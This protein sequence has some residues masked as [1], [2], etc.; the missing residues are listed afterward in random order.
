MADEWMD[1]IDNAELNRGEGEQETVAD[2]PES[3]LAEPEQKQADEAQRRSRDDKG[4]FAPKSE[5][6]SQQAA[7]EVEADNP[8]AQEAA[9][10]WK[11]ASWKAEELQAWKDIPAPARAAIERREKEIQNGFA[12]IAERTRVASAFEQ[13][14]QPFVPILQQTG[15]HP[16]AAMQEALQFVSTLN[17]GSPE[18][19]A[20]AIAK[21]A[22]RYGVQ[23]GGAAE[24]QQQQ[25]PGD[26]FVQA[27]QAELMNVR[28][29]LQAIQYER[30]QQ[31]Q[32][33]AQQ[34]QRNLMSTIEQFAADKPD[35]AAL[36]PLV[37]EKLR[38]GGAN[39]LDEAYKAAKAELQGIFTPQQAAEHAAKVA[40]ARK[41][42]APNVKAR[43]APA[44]TSLKPKTWQ[45]GFEQNAD[46]LLARLND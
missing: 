37:A 35:F 3:V 21:L 24:A 25:Q 20:Q 41:A 2:E 36:R 16:I 26:P 7:E 39:S 10:G 6:S 15:V 23:I 43:G 45:E 28:N 5:T 44:A 22:Q 29:Q 31:A 17:A 1:A 33:A 4:R 14:V 42:S 11:P 38:S 27:T 34:E 9:A 40:Q 46:R 32:W 8:P 19:R 30:Q 13:A 12:Q 18:Q